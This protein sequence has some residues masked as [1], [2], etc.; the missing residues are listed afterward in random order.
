[1]RTLF[2]VIRTRGPSWDA[3]KPL[4][5]QLQWDEHARFM[6][7]LAADG[8]IVLGGPLGEGPDVLLAIKAANEAEARATLGG[9]PWSESGMLDIKS[10]QTWTILLES[11]QR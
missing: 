7:A 5:S 8:L 10:I 6:N 11:A 2:A 1:M 9:D 3:D 4:R